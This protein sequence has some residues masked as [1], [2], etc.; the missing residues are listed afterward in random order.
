MN[1]DDILAKPALPSFISAVALLIVTAFFFLHPVGTSD[2][3]WQIKTGEIIW[4]THSIPRTDIFSFTAF[5]NAWINHEWLAEVIFYL[6]WRLGGFVA[7]SFFSFLLG[8][9]FAACLF[10][11]IRK[12]SGSVT[13]GLLLSFAV[14]LVGAPRFQQLRPDLFAFLFFVAMLLLLSTADR[15]HAKRLWMLIPAQL[16]WSNI[17]GSAIIAPF[18]ILLYGITALADA[19]IHKE[20]PP[21]K[22]GQFTAIV[23]LSYMTLLANPYTVE[24]YLFPFTHLL[25]RYAILATLDWRAPTWFAPQADIASWGLALLALAFILVV[26]RRPKQVRLPLLVTTTI[27]FIAGFRMMRFVPF[28]ATSAAFLL[29]ASVDRNVISRSQR[30]Q[31]VRIAVLILCL[32]VPILANSYGPFYGIRPEKGRLDFV[33]G[34]PM[35]IG[36]DEIDF[37][38]GAVDFLEDKNLKGRV[39]NDMAYGGYLIF[40]QWPE[41]GVFFDTRTPIYGDQFYQEYV[42]AL[43]NEKMFDDIV[44]RYDITCV[45]YD[46]RQ[47]KE[48]G[49]LEFLFNNPHW[50]LIYESDNAV[51]F[52]KI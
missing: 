24:A 8:V 47:I 43:R 30:I 7:L 33:F 14:F 49:E 4:Q 5:G 27:C 37:P 50:R 3:F 13:L 51:I 11:G 6:I 15:L 36:L 31:L 19:R 38:V 42:S 29:A 16:F 21:F 9:S 18:F 2:L 12:L 52:I 17:H 26:I 25:Q 32:G 20:P 1:Q 28:A 23:L 41:E 44:E 46:M 10:I 45:L 34:L 40:R 39:F 35:G 48:T 22:V